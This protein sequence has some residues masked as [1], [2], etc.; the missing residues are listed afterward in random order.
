MKVFTAAIFFRLILHRILTTKHWL[1]L[2]GLFTGVVLVQ[3]Q[4]SSENTS[5]SGAEDMTHQYP[6]FG[7][8]CVC[9]ACCLSGF[10]GVYFELL[11]KST[12]KSVVM[13]NIQLSVYGIVAGILQV[14]IQDKTLVLHK[15]F[16]H[17]YDSAVWVMIFVQSLGGLLVAVVVRYADN[18]LKNFATSVALLLT[19]LLSI[20]IFNT[21][22][23][24]YLVM[25]NVVVIISTVYYNFLEPPA[26]DL[27]KQSPEQLVVIEEEDVESKIAV[28]DKV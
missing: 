21:N 1:A 27:G 6:L 8:A 17:G 7:F 18:I 14:F 10:A 22:P 4:S 9:I 2:I 28:S 19:L 25:G 23:T 12:K 20:V 16:F 15:G 11:L 3:V 26:L 24:I 5:D 13:R